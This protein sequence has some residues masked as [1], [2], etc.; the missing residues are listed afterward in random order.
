MAT[1][2]RVP[3]AP[4]AA[5]FSLLMGHPF[6]RLP[7]LHYSYVERHW[8]LVSV[9]NSASL[10]LTTSGQSSESIVDTIV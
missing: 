4:A 2:I 5:Y 9:L 7:Q 3:G 1:T 10:D 8:T 6:L